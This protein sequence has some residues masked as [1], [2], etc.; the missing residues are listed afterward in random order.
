MKVFKFG[1]SSVAGADEIERVMAWISRAYTAD[2]EIAVVLSAMG[3]VTDTLIE[4]ARKAACGD[5]GY[6]TP[7]RE[8]ESRHIRVVEALFPLE[9]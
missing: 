8:I 7:M 9:A 1:G 3:G 5:S 6:V 4:T 2:R